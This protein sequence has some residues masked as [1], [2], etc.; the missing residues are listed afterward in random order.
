MVKRAAGEALAELLET[1]RTASQ[2]AKKIS[3]G[4]IADTAVEQV[5]GISKN[6][7]P[8]G[9]EDL[10][11]KKVTSTQLKKMQE[12]DAAKS[13]SRISSTRLTLKRL[14]IQ[15]YQQIQQGILQKGKEREQ[16][17]LEEEREKAEALQAEKKE[18]KKTKSKK[19][20]LPKGPRKRG[21]LGIFAKQRKGTGE[22]RL[23][24]RG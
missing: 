12:D 13:Q 3:P 24:K 4:K 7:I 15:R 21:R 8:L 1:G 6:D 14:I 11:G 9:L 20:K 23:G 2:Q 10:K 19:I 5:S 17:G 18:K 16:A 22:I